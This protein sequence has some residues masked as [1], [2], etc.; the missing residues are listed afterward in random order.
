MKRV[1]SFKAQYRQTPPRV[2]TPP[3]PV[4]EPLSPVLHAAGPLTAPPAGGAHS[5]TAPGSGHA[6]G[7]ATN[8]PGPWDLA[9]AP[10]AVFYDALPRSAPLPQPPP[11]YSFPLGS[12]IEALADAAVSSQ[13]TSPAHV[14]PPRRAVHTA[15]SPTA[16]LHATSER[17]PR[18][19]FARDLTQPYSERPAKRARSEHHASP[20]YGTHQSRPATSH[21]PGYNVEQMMDSGLRM[22][23]DS[24]AVAPPPPPPQQ[25]QQ[26]NGGD[27]MLS[28]AELLL[29]FSNVSAHTA[30]T[31]PSTAKRWSVS[32][33]S[34]SP[35]LLP[36]QTQ[37]KETTSP[38]ALTI[39][40]ASNQHQ[41]KEGPLDSREP[42][43]LASCPGNVVDAASA[44]QT[45][46]PPEETVATIAQAVMQDAR[47]A[48]EPKPKKQQSASKGKPRGS[49]NTPSTGKRKRSTPKPKHASST[50]TS[51]GPDQLQSPQSLPADQPGVIASNDTNYMSHG[52]EQPSP[53][54]LHN[55]RHSF[56]ISFSQL[57]NGA[58]S[59]TS[60]RARSVPLGVE[61]LTSA[62]IENLHRPN[63]KT[64]LE[65]P[66]LICAACK[67]F[68]SEVKVGDG[69]QWIGCDGCKE[70]YHY[71]CAGF[72]S[73]REVRDVNKFYCDPCRPKFG[74][75]TSRST[76]ATRRYNSNLA[77]R[78][79]S[80]S[81]S[82]QRST[83]PV[84]MKVSSR[85]PTT[86]PNITTLPLSRMET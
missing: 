60:T 52:V 73:E 33:A 30:Q 11:S 18:H 56:S 43:E 34:P 10:A 31:P 27:K 20:T 26:S 82:I 61:Q 5:D 62:P 69:E 1:T 22:Y 37:P 48:E 66:D 45:Q 81:E 67:S 72:N 9:H 6:N 64:V 3:R 68:D 65:Q 36:Q 83:M 16:R 13:R 28:D 84:S 46:T 76:D 47:A 53:S 44:S 51:A 75:T 50:S 74:E 8:A 63:N 23:Q 41:S 4:W 58:A 25:Q 59:S 12:P 49:R 71:A 77:Q 24:R 42:R 79:A 35:A 38:H 2:A 39:H 86:T 15:N 78:F 54:T 19:A 70:W 57:P 55:R 21:I 80:P 85:L 14:E 7:G 32:Q 29:F 40:N 17:A